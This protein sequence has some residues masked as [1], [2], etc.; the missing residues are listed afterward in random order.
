MFKGP[1]IIYRLGGWGEGGAGVA[2]D[3]GLNKVKFSQSPFESYFT[4]VIPPN[5][6]F[7][8][9]R[10]LPSHVFIIQAKLSD[11]PLNPSK[12]FSDPPFW[13]LSYD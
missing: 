3:L 2:E 6:T 11:P 12:V 4:E 1:V 5:Q 7:D 8:D 9:F 13:V 10:D